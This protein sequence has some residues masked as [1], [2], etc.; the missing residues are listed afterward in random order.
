MKDEREL[1]HDMQTA[2]WTLL[3]IFGGFAALFLVA[4]MLPFMP[5][6]AAILLFFSP[7]IVLG[8]SIFLLVY[9]LD[10]DTIEID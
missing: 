6:V 10:T 7:L 2:L 8:S 1:E 4:M 9:L 3:G 5:I